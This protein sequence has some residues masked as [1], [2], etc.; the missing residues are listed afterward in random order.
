MEKYLIVTDTTSA[1]NKEIAAAHGIELISLSVIVDGQEYKDQVDI[2][3]EQLYDYLKDGKTPS[4]SQPN[5]GYLI[6]KMEAWQKENYEAI[7]VVTCS[8]DLSGTNNGFHLAKDTVGLDNVY[9]YDSRQVGAPVMDMAI[10]AK[11]LADEGKDVDE[12]FKVLE[13]KTKHSFSFLYP[14]NFDQLSRSGR[15]SP[16]AARMASML[17]IKALLCLDEQGKS[18]DKYSMSRTEVKVLK[19]ITDKF[20]ELGVN[21]EKYK[22]YISHADNIVFAKKSKLLLQ[23]TFHG[24]EVE[25]NNLPAVLTCHGGLACCALHS[26]YKI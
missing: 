10:R 21:A 8:A 9:I 23:T 6:E 22:I 19:A 3:T 1:I 18:V 2:S 24:I 17:K 12:I 5:T 4:T 7:I 25:I 14:D 11:Q 26:T 15:L 20:H 16:M 13:E